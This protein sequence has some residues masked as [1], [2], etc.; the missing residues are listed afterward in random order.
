MKLELNL[1]NNGKIIVSRYYNL[2]QKNYPLDPTAIGGVIKLVDE[3]IN[4]DSKKE[5]QIYD[6]QVNILVDGKEE[7]TT[8]IKKYQGSKGPNSYKTDIKEILPTIIKMLNV[9]KV[10]NGI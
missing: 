1:K 10:R 5:K 3:H 4:K 8:T 6:V 2:N 7:F 9:N